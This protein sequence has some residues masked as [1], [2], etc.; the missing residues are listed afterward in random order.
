[1]SFLSFLIPSGSA[2]AQQQL[3]VSSFLFFFSIPSK[4]AHL[5]ETTRKQSTANLSRAVLCTRAPKQH[6]W[7]EQCCIVMDLFVIRI[8]LQKKRTLINSVAR[9][10]RGGG[11]GK[12]VMRKIRWIEGEEKLSLERKVSPNMEKR[13]PMEVENSHWREKSHLLWEKNLPWREQP[14]RGAA[15]LHCFKEN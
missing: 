11:D 1:M 3:V 8:W 12:M 6:I 4:S 15:L 10:K 13:P 2:H 5:C 7:V 9:E 14:P